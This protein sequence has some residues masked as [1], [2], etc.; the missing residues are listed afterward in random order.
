MKQYNNNR[1]L[2]YKIITV[3]NCASEIVKN[4]ELTCAQSKNPGYERVN[5][6]LLTNNCIH[7]ISSSRSS[8]FY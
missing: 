4:Q 3:S 2:N 8:S 7:H 6:F 1:I 5:S